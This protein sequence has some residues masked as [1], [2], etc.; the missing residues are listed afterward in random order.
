MNDNYI[1]GPRSLVLNNLPVRPN[2]LQ[3]TANGQFSGQYTHSNYGG[4]SATIT[5]PK[6]VV[7][8]NQIVPNSVQLTAGAITCQDDGAGNIAGA[9]CAGTVNMVSHGRVALTKDDLYLSL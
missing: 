1:S 4:G 8:A 2:S 6:G 7:S 3:L 5:L 9:G